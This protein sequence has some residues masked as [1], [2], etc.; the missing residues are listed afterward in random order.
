MSVQKVNTPLLSNKEIEHYQLFKSL[1][2]SSYLLPIPKGTY[3]NVTSAAMNLYMSFGGCVYT[4]ILGI[5]L[6]VK[7]LT[8][9]IHL[10]SL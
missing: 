6:G 5:Y 2:L 8:Q 7:L 10:S 4:F 1:P 9:D 3:L